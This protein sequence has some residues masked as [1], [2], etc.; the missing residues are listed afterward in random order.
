[1]CKLCIYYLR[2]CS[3]VA[4]SQWRVERQNR[5]LLKAMRVA[6]SEG[7]DWQ[8]ELQKFLLG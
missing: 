7:G 2:F 5:S 8:K 3:I 1:M 4:T 6:H